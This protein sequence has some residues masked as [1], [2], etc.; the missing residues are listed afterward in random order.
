MVGAEDWVREAKRKGGFVVAAGEIAEHGE[1]VLD[2]YQR[3]FSVDKKM[4]EVP[5]W[6]KINFFFFIW[7]LWGGGGREKLLFQ[8][9]IIL[10]WIC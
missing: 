5:I 2:R 8:L 1:V 10:L 3:N 9:V 7:G 6:L 4:D